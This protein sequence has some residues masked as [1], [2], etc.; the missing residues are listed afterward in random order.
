MKYEIDKVEE[1]NLPFTPTPNSI[2]EGAQEQARALMDVVEQQHLYQ[3]L[4]GK[5]FLNVE[6]WQ[7]V[8]SFTGLSATIEYSRPL[9]VEDDIGYEARAI[10]QDKNGNEVSAGE[11]ECRKSEKGKQTHSHNQLRS[12]AQTRAISK[13]LRNKL[14]F[15]AVMAG[16]S[17]TTAEEMDEAPEPRPAVT[18]TKQQDANAI[19]IEMFKQHKERCLSYVDEDTMNQLASNLK[20]D[21]KRIA[22]IKRTELVDLLS[23]C[24]D[25][26]ARQDT[27]QEEGEDIQPFLLEEGEETDVE[28]TAFN[29]S[30]E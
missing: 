29:E 16:F 26:K 12:M 20:L 9:D 23:A 2:I 15:I 6:A 11:S 19:T 10:V 5:K 28:Q 4:R 13:S 1:N 30:E 14:A 25:F 27:E 3:I 18:V 24:M 22:D 8:A 21:G 7:L 17:P